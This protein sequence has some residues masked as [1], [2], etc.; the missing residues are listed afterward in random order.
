MEQARVHGSA[1]GLGFGPWHGVSALLY[2]IACAAVL[3]V[4]WKDALR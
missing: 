1:L 4:V 3:V 2:L